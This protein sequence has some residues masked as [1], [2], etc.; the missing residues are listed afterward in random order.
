MVPEGDMN[1]A[2][3]FDDSIKQDIHESMWIYSLE[4]ARKELLKSP[5]GIDTINAIK[6]S[7]VIINV[8]NMRMHPTGARGEQFGYRIDIYARQCE[9]ELVFFANNCA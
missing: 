9:N 5:V 2:K 6:N 3:S 8:I 4:D 7:D 1:Y